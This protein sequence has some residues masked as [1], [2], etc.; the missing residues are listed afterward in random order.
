[1]LLTLDDQSL[2]PRGVVTPE[3]V[4]LE[5]DTAGVGSRGV[6]FILDVTL[7]FAVLFAI[8]LALAI[9]VGS[10]AGSALAIPLAILFAI[11]VLVG[12]PA[13][14][15]TFWGGRTLGNAALGLRAV[16]LEGGP[17]RF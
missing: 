9:I 2:Q 11:L 5:F 7:Q 17:I 6:G 13:A 8:G 12:Y 14:M 4:V 16:T 3:A 10:T 1:M 15:E